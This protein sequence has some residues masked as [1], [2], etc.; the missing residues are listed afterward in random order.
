MCYL[1]NRS[2]AD[3]FAM[4]GSW[5]IDLDRRTMAL[6]AIDA[7]V[8]ARLLDK[9]VHHREPKAGAFTPRFGGEEGLE[10]FIEDV[11]GDSAAGIRDAQ[12]HVLAGLDVAEL[13]RI[14]VVEIGIGG[15]DR[16]MA[17]GRQSR[18]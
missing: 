12:E 17:A 18:A 10:D 11:K 14:G 13:R 6:L 4:L 1:P 5:Q 9:A 16:Q 7:D 15:F 3:F 8:A 2:H